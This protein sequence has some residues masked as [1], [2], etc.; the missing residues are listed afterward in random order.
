MITDIIR[1]LR[2]LYRPVGIVNAGPSKD[3]ASAKQVTNQPAFTREI[4]R[5]L[6]IAGN[7]PMT[8]NS[9]DTIT[10]K[11]NASRP[12][13]SVIEYFDSPESVCLTLGLVAFMLIA[14]D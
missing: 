2:G 3:A 13:A 14:I 9:D 7:S 6:A 11:V 5:S 8:I 12:I 4:L 10:N 1:K